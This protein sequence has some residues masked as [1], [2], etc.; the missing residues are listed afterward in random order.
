M[1]RQRAGTVG[2]WVQATGLRTLTPG[3]ASVSELWN[4]QAGGPC[5]SWEGASTTACL[6]SQPPH[7]AS[8]PG[9]E[10]AVTPITRD[11]GNTVLVLFAWEWLHSPKIARL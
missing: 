7:P 3:S 11:P 10:D 6:A 8:W 2:T 9:L 4:S 5:C 1:Q